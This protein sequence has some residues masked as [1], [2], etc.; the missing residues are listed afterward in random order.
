MLYLKLSEEKQ[1]NLE[2][3]AS[4]YPLISVKN[5]TEVQNQSNKCCISSYFQKSE[6]RLRPN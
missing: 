6:G 3:G 4:I 2:D 1:L 5:L